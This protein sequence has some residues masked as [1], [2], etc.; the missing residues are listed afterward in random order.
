MQR[1]E[2]ETG[3]AIHGMVKQILGLVVVLHFA[4]II[5]FM[6]GVRSGPWPMWEGP[7]ADF[8]DVPRFLNGP[9]L[10]WSRKY[11]STLR[12]DETGRY[13]SLRHTPVEVRMHARFLDAEGKETGTL[14]FPH[15]NS[16]FWIKPW[17]RMIAQ[18]LA[19]DVM[20]EPPQGE[21]SYPPGTKPPQFAVWR[22]PKPD[23]PVQQLTWVPEHLLS[24]APSPPDWGPDEWGL[25]LSRSCARYLCR[26]YGAASV[27]IHRHWKYQQPPFAVL[28]ERPPDKEAFGERISNYGKVSHAG[29]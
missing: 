25:A 11:L 8:A 23:D 19:N 16:P 7:G 13:P 29:K 3:A 28:A 18:A 20:R 10:E 22:S 26:T 2:Q 6:L 4:F 21:K 27:E 14:D 15:S 9:V 17:E 24:R 5:V 12:L 1:E